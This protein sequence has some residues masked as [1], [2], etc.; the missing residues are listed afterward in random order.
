MGFGCQ[1]HATALSHGRTVAGAVGVR[2]SGGSYVSLYVIPKAPLH[3][4]LMCWGAHTHSLRLLR[5]VWRLGAAGQLVACAR[6]CPGNPEWHCTDASILHASASQ[7]LSPPPFAALLLCV[8]RASDHQ[9]RPPVRAH[10]CEPR[11][12]RQHLSR[13]PPH[14]H[15]FLGSAPRV[16]QNGQAQRQCPT[17]IRCPP[18]WKLVP[19]VQGVTK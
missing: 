7:P 15:C 13:W 3:G 9:L 18:V 4:P 5:I 1:G 16:S 2:E 10:P 12:L 8:L 6:Y 19:R 14:A 11:W 17:S